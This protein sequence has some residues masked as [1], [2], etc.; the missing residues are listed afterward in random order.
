MSTLKVRL[1]L[2]GFAIVG[3]LPNSLFAQVGNDNPTGPAGAFNGYVNSDGQLKVGFGENEGE[4]KFVNGDGVTRTYSGRLEIKKKGNQDYA[5]LQDDIV[6][7]EIPLASLEAEAAAFRS[8]LKCKITL[9]HRIPD[10]LWAP[11]AW[12]GKR[13]HWDGQ[14]MLDDAHDQLQTL[15]SVES[16]GKRIYD[17]S[18]CSVRQV[19]MEPRN[20]KVAFGMLAFA[21]AER[22]CQ[23]HFPHITAILALAVV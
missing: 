20:V 14:D 8:G 10:D 17:R 1:F 5:V 19:V 3:L 2:S 18:F 21:S 4:L 12:V 16:D 22:Y 15:I 13:E 6:I 11:T 9:L 7:L 23:E